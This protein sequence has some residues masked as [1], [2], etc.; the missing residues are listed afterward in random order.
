MDGLLFFYVPTLVILYTLGLLGISEMGQVY[1]NMNDTLFVKRE[2]AGQTYL[3]V[4]EDRKKMSHMH[5]IWY[6][7]KG[8]YIHMTD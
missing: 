7:T 4:V 5:T 1:V 6:I 8:E 2:Q 3:F